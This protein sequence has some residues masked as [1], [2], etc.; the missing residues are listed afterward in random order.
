[1]RRAHA[2]ARSCH[3]G[4]SFKIGALNLH[5]AGNAAYGALNLVQALT[6]S[7]DVF[8]YKVGQALNGAGGGTAA[9][10]VGPRARH[11]RARPG[12]DIPGE[13]SAGQGF[14][15]TPA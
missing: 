13:N 4:G 12:I 1:M 6:V 9:P 14:L 10:E 7:S 11:R 5:N 15:P 8:F 3:D 2:R